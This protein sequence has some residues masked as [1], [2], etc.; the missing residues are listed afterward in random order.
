M[1]THHPTEP[2][3]DIV[4]SGPYARNILRIN[5]LGEQD[6]ASPCKSL[7][8]LDLFGWLAALDDVRNWVI[9]EAA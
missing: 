7:I 4:Q 3:A 6:K 8:L 1:S 2:V 9:Q 5:D